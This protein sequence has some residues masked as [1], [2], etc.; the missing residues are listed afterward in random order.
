MALQHHALNDAYYRPTPTAAGRRTDHSDLSRGRQLAD[1]A[2]T[3]GYGRS[4]SVR[5][6]LEQVAC[7]AADHDDVL[8]VGL[9][10]SWARGT[11]TPESDVDLVL[12]VVNVHELLVDDRWLWQFG[13]VAGVSNENWG[14]V[15]SRR[16]QYV[17]GPEVEFGL[18]TTEWAAVPLDPGTR[19]VVADGFVILHDPDG[20]LPAST[21]PG[22]EA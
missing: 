12:V 20:L 2:G 6:L 5:T 21:A 3:R 10:G 15:Q 1:G 14:L 7:W 19:R 17:D 4:M 8:A 22:I 11:A 13:E 9:A 18:T 16:V